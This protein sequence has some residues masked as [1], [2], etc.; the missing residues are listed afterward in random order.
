MHT[1]RERPVELKLATLAASFAL[2]TGIWSLFAAK[3][4]LGTGWLFF[5]CFSMFKYLI[6]IFWLALSYNGRAWVRYAY[7]VLT[8]ISVYQLSRLGSEAFQDSPLS[9]TVRR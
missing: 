2:L 7:L 3:P 4:L 6:G 1:L 9:S 8:L 5:A